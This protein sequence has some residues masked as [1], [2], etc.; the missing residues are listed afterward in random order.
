MQ[1]PL[2]IAAWLTS[3]GT[4]YGVA[5][6]EVIVRTVDGREQRLQLPIPAAPKSSSDGDSEMVRDLIQWVAEQEHGHEFTADAAAGGA[7]YQVPASGSFRV[8]LRDLCDR[9][10]IARIPGN[11]GF[12]VV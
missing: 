3:G 12:R 8:A 5:V 2:D 10:L 1:S 4:L 7:G 6:S 9:D 11:R